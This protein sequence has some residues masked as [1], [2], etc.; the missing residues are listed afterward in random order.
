MRRLDVKRGTKVIVTVGSHT[1]EKGTISMAR[2]Y[3]SQS[4][5]ARIRLDGRK[6][7]VLL[8]IGYLKAK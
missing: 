6:D 1:G 3:N 7:T 8:P 4:H 5:A 2:D